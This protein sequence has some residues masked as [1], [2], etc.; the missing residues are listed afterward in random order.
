MRGDVPADPVDQAG[1]EQRKRL[2]VRQPAGIREEILQA[3][4]QLERA[5]SA[6]SHPE[7][8]PVCVPQPGGT[9]AGGAG[10]ADKGAVHREAEGGPGGNP[11][12][13]PA[14][15]AGDEQ[16]AGVRGAERED[17]AF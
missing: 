7:L 11:A 17:G 9:G 15:R 13:N 14:H 4:A 3:L 16:S 12:E 6:R 5:D 2:A 8:Y 10:R 1:R